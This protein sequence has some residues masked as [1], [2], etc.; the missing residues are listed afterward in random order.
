[1]VV[2]SQ[3]PAV[4]NL[5]FSSAIFRLPLSVVNAPLEM[6]KIMLELLEEVEVYLLRIGLVV[7]LALG[8]VRLILWEIRKVLED[9][10]ALRAVSGTRPQSHRQLR[11]F[12]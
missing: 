12:L 6:L 3:T 5:L 1:L 7:V 11:W 9:I 4:H 8:I 10:Q 2:F